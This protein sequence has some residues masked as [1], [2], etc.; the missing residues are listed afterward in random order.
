MSQP[1]DASSCHERI[2]SAKRCLCIQSSK[3]LEQAYQIRQSHYFVGTSDLALLTDKQ[4]LLLTLAGKKPVSEIASGHWETT[5]TG[6]SSKPDSVDEVAIFLESLGLSYAL[7]EDHHATQAIVGT[8]SDDVDLF[9]QSSNTVQI[10]HLLGYPDSAVQA[11]ASGKSLSSEAQEAAL[12]KAGI[13]LSFSP[14]RLSETFWEQEM[15]VIVDWFGVVKE[16]GLVR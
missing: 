6:R 2:E 13:P 8:T 1:I 5:S 11:F 10:G 15:L 14:F 12:R 7:T 16:Y 3:L 9:Q 4:C